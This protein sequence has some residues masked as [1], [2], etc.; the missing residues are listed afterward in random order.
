[1]QLLL[2]VPSAI[3]QPSK[4]QMESKQFGACG[5]RG[6]VPFHRADASGDIVD[7]VFA[8]VEFDG[9]RAP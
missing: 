8:G 9:S 4:A 6:C 7:R 1:V 3:I 5:L 2:L